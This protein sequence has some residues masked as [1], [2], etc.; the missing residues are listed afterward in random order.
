[1]ITEESYRLIDAYIREELNATDKVR[2]YSLLKDTEFL[3]ALNVQLEL[4]A[5]HSEENKNR[6]LNPNEREHIIG[7]IKQAEYD[8]FKK[9]KISRIIPLLWYSIA[10]SI[11]LGIFI[12]IGFVFDRETDLT[13]YYVAYANWDTLPSFINRS[14]E[15]NNL[16]IAEE[17]FKA[18]D[19][20]KAISIFNMYHIENP[21]NPQVLAY[22]GAAYLEQDDDTMALKTFNLLANSNS[23]DSSLGLWYMALTH[24]KYNRK[25]DAVAVLKKI[26]SNPNN[27]NADEATTILNE[28]D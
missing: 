26:S 25:D 28:I 14:E 1:M 5:L 18:K 9:K 16:V 20:Q 4:Y 22:L 3:E 17:A 11:I 27:Y 15:Q 10:A 23:V 2:F 13:S 12:T 24:L 19:F 6:F 7:A 21:D 8:Y